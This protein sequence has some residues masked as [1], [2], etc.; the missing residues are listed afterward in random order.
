MTDCSAATSPAAQAFCCEFTLVWTSAR[1]PRVAVSEG[2]H[3][4]MA[5][6]K[7]TSGESTSRASKTP[8][9]T[10]SPVGNCSSGSCF[11]H[12]GWGGPYLPPPPHPGVCW[13]AAAADCWVGGVLIPANC[14]LSRNTTKKKQR[15]KSKIA[16]SWWNHTPELLQDCC[17]Q[18]LSN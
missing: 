12:E 3:A 17:I 10:G 5:S 13:K 7:A 4:N 15:E 6:T 11:S 1:L 8:P 2:L 16:W 18:T 14:A 9:Y